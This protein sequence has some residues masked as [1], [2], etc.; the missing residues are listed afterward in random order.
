MTEGAEFCRFTSS[1]QPGFQVCVTVTDGAGSHGIN[2]NCTIEVNA[3]GY[4]TATHFDT[5][6]FDY[7]TIGGTRY[8]GNTGPYGAAVSA[9]STFQWQS[10]YSITSAGW[11]ICFGE[12]RPHCT[13]PCDPTGSTLNSF[14]LPFM[15]A[16]VAV[17]TNGWV[18]G[19]WRCRLRS[20]VR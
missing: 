10:D 1:V 8:Q 3:N 2:E 7:V 5:E 13:G 16:L 4:L 15:A 17:C 20:H 9:G 19:R 11:T 14:N 6:R 18:P 12:T